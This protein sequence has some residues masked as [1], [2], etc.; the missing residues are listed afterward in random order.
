[1]TFRRGGWPHGRL[2]ERSQQAIERGIGGFHLSSL[3]FSNKNGGWAHGCARRKYARSA[4]NTVKARGLVNHTAAQVT[5]GCHGK[6]EE[7]DTMHFTGQGAL[8]DFCVCV[9]VTW[10]WIRQLRICAPFLVSAGNHKF[11]Y[12]PHSP[13]SRYGHQARASLD[14]ICHGSQQ[15]C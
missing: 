15:H 7:E 4:E 6:R 2:S 11:E 3:T 9:F 14:S 10:P 1:M 8:F 13:N 12:S 5:C